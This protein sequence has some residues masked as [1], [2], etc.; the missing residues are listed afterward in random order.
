M[1][2]SDCVALVAYVAALP[3]PIVRAP[4]NLSDAMKVE[5]GREVFPSIGC[6]TCHLPDPGPIRGLYSDLLLH[7]MGP[8]DS[9]LSAGYGVPRA[10]TSGDLA[11]AQEWRTPPLW[12]LRDSGPYLHDG[13]AR[14]IDDVFGFHGGEATEPARLYAKL[15]H[16]AKTYLRAFLGSLAAPPATMVNAVGTSKHVTHLSRRPGAPRSTNPAGVSSL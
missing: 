11:S 1:N 6:A 16:E 7:D 9:S 14:T 2:E 3:A 13:R 8:G 5:L 15:S 10:E 12:G 4:R